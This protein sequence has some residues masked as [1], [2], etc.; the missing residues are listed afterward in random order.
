MYFS[1]ETQ[2]YQIKNEGSY[3]GYNPDNILEERL[4]ILKNLWI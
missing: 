3:L 4:K 2:E 1:T